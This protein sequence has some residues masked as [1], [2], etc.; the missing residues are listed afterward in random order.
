MR[1]QVWG[2]G[3][4]KLIWS[5][6]KETA[7]SQTLSQNKLKSNIIGGEQIVY[8]IKTETVWLVAIGLLNRSFIGQVAEIRY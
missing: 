8:K 5:S 7:Q 3:G 2:A 1:K 6:K 4:D